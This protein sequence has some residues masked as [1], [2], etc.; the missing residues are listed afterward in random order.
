[1]RN[2]FLL[3]TL[4]VFAAAVILLAFSSCRAVTKRNSDKAWEYLTDRY[5]E[6]V[7]EFK[8]EK[9]K[10]V[11]FSSR[12]F[13]G[14]DVKVKMNFK[15]PLQ[16]NYLHLLHGKQTEETVNGFLSELLADTPY[17][18]KDFSE[19]YVYCSL[20][21]MKKFDEY[22]SS[23]S[24]GLSYTVY[25]PLRMYSA[26]DFISFQNAFFELTEKDNIWKKMFTFRFVDDK[27]FEEIRA[28]K[29]YDD[30]N[31]VP[32]LAVYNFGSHSIKEGMLDKG[33]VFWDRS[34]DPRR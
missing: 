14:E 6:D 13:P 9:D 11:Y 16:D 7:F 15:T 24:S 12:K 28:G 29:K 31:D 20:E 34:A 21:D 1:M 2:K 23:A 33:W 17:Y 30:E 19:E 18:L 27:V 32:G 4:S 10:T 26:D 8:S 3:K 22:I 5:S 25:V